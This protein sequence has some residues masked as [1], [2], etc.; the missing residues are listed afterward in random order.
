[1]DEALP[2]GH[3]GETKEQEGLQGGAPSVAG[4]TP[5][6]A[7]M[8]ASQSIH[9]IPRSFG[10]KPKQVAFQKVTQKALSLFTMIFFSVR[11]NWKYLC[12][13]RTFPVPTKIIFNA[14]WN[15]S[16]LVISSA[17]SIWSGSGSSGTFPV[18]LPENSQK[19]PE[20]F[21]H[22]P[23]IIRHVPKPIWL[24]GILW[25]NFSV[26]PELFRYPLRNVSV[27]SETFSV[28]FSQTPC[29]VFSR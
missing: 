22:P 8:R 1:M 18:F 10:I 16:R 13:L 6:G 28:I 7:P 15:N 19:F 12:G 5:W 26:S 24:Y 27:S 25:N 20:W 29:L 14:F 17:K 11:S 3:N 9:V 21:W 4:H 2:Q 23:R